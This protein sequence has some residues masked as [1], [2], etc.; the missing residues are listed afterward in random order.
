MVRKTIPLLLVLAFAGGCATHPK[1]AKAPVSAGA[2]LPP[3]QKALADYRAI[4]SKGGWVTVPDGPKLVKGDTGERVALLRKRLFTTGDLTKGKESN[5][6]DDDLNAAVQRFQVRH[7]LASPTSSSE[8]RAAG[9]G[10]EPD[11]AVAKETLA[12]LN[13][14]VEERVRQ[15]ETGI[16][17]RKELG[18]LGDR[19]VVV[20]IPDFRLKVVDKGK[21]VLGMKV[22]VGRGKE[23]QTPLLDSRI[24]YLIL[25]PRWNVPE[26]IFEK[27]LLRDLRNDP[28]YLAR[29]N[30]AVIQTSGDKTGPVDAS[31]IDWNQVN[32]KNPHLRIVQRE[33]AGNSLGRIK[34]MFPNPYAVYLHDTPQKK[35]FARAM[36]ALS[37]GCV[38]VENP[39][40]L[41][42]YLMKDDPQ[43][44]RERIESAIGSGRNRDVPLP[45]PI[46][47]HIIYLTSWVDDE[48]QVNFRDDVYGR[49]RL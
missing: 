18:S 27:E 30:M 38:R 23:W 35:L 25:N 12:A 28:T 2:P 46:D 42:V 32:G 9:S 1:P 5:V 49:E 8:S 14:P 21:P 3:M 44:T 29:H 13:V 20:N 43:W 39:M 11:G 37:H 36:R 47:L 17:R 22:V 24:N 19:Y 40:E 10:M 26:G 4:A 15:L 31:T 48:G 16:E 34:F 41:A 45:S 6:F 7:G 33:G